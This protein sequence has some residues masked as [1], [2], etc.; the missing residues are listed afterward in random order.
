MRKRASGTA[1][2]WT[3]F[4][5]MRIKHPRL[6][7]VYQAFDD[8]REYG[9]S[10]PFEPKGYVKLLAPTHS[11]KSTSVRSYIETVVVD[12]AIERG[13][14]SADTDRAL[15][16]REQRLVLHVTLSP[17]ATPKSLATDILQ[18]LGDPQ[19]HRGTQAALETRLYRMLQETGVELVILDELQHMSASSLRMGPD[20]TMVKQSQSSPMAV[21]STLKTMLIRGLVPM[22]FV[23]TLDAAKFLKFDGQIGGRILKDLDFSPLRWETPGDRK[24]FQEWCGK[25]GIK[26]FE[27]GLLPKRPNL[28]EGDI[29]V[30]LWAASGGKIGFVSRIVQDAV[31]HAKERESETLDRSDLEWAVDHCAIP[32]G[33]CTTNP[34]R[35]RPKGAGEG[36]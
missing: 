27:H 1:T 10:V 34:F 33:I 23:G 25:V 5:K 24:F 21:A 3:E 16:A 13:L 31:I 4:T 28:V 15:I 20:G 30:N 36:A 6:E 7:A 12:E 2:V 17:N 9:A 11:G 26:V 22:A 8:L 18:R 14:F 32:N 19:A 29:P 35:G